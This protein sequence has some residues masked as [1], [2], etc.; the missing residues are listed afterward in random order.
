MNSKSI[1]RLVFLIIAL[2]SLAL[3]GTREYQR[4]KAIAAAEPARD[5]IAIIE[6]NQVVMTYF[7]GGIRCDSCKTIETL[8][9]ETAEQNLR[10]EVA[11]GKVIFRV[12]DLDEPQNHHF[13]NDYQLTSKSVILSFRVDGKEE[14]WTNMEKVWDLLD[15]PE[16]FRAYLTQP[17]QEYLKS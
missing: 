16:A 5:E 13:Q 17:V 3:W 2:G 14:K 15:E 6:G 8:T 1:L 10:E 7:R 12:I 9:T 11:S 4:S